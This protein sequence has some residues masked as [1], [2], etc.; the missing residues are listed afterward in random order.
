MTSTIYPEELPLNRL[1]AAEFDVKPT[2]ESRATLEIFLTK[3]RATLGP[4]D[5]IGNTKLKK[6]PDFY[7]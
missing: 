3:R 1:P 6:A 7:E 2:A 4:H 5:F